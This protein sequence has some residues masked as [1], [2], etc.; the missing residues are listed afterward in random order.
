[1]KIYAKFLMSSVFAFFV[2]V[3]VWAQDCGHEIM[4][5][6]DEQSVINDLVQRQDCLNK[7]LQ[8]QDNDYLKIEIYDLQD[9]LKQAES[10]L[11]TAKT[12]IEDLEAS[13]H[14][15]G[16]RLTMAEDEIKWLTSKAP[17]RKPKTPAS[18]PT[19]TVK[20]GTH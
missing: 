15:I 5:N 13:L 1:M 14:L 11:S 2:G 20:K 7:K 18:Q 6:H 8:Y 9:K 16:L 4:W 17:A 10:D 12:K 19:P 3:P